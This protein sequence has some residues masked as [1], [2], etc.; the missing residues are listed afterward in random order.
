MPFLFTPCHDLF[1]YHIQ[2]QLGGGWLLEFYSPCTG[3]YGM[4]S[5]VGRSKVRVSY[6]V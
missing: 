5:W 4:F 1:V 6:S 3:T 2:L